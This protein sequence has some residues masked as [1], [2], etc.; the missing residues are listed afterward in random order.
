MIL[1]HLAAA[2]AGA[3]AFAAFPA[4]A[5]CQWEWLCNGDGACKHMPV[6]DSVNEV[7]PPRPEGTQPPAMPPLAM[8]PHKIAGTGVGISTTLTC[9]HIMRKGKSGRWYW[10][11]ACF[12]SDPAKA[13]DS[14]PPFAN[15]VRCD[16]P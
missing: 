10:H 15:I 5:E 7:P 9:E 11:E 13:R 12:C 3:A 2:L 16:A 6:C 14:S 1:R 8:R 4:A